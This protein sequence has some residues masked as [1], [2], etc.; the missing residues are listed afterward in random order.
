MNYNKVYTQDFVNGIGVGVSLF[1]Q[2]CQRAYEGNPCKGCF[3]R[4]T[5]NPSGGKEYTEETQ[6]EILKALSPDFISH[7]SILG[8]EPL[9]ECNIETLT[10]LCR[11]AKE[12]YPEKKIWVWTGYTFEELWS[13]RGMNGK[14]SDMDILLSNIDVLVDGPYI[15]SLKPSAKPWT[16]S[17]NQRVLNS[18]KSLAYGQVILL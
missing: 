10:G 1:V 15:E 7:L 5:W 17:G 4:I 9:D 8:G 2:G 13:K 14:T 3:N 16:G 18:Q 11:K 12:L 6:N